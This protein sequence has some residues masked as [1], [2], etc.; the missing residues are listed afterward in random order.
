MRTLGSIIAEYRKKNGI[1][2]TELADSLNSNGY[3]LTNKAISKW[4][5]DVAAP[6]IPVFITLCR[7]LGIEDIYEVFTGY[8]PFNALSSLNTEGREKALEYI[9]LLSE[10]ERY[11]KRSCEII[12]F[13]R[14][15]PLYDLPASAGMG[16]FLD[17]ENYNMIE[18]G[19]EVPAEADFGIRISG[20]SM[21]PRFVHGQIV[22][23]HQ[24]DF[25]QNG[26]IGIFYLD[27]QAFCKKL[28]DDDNGLYLLSLNEEYAPIP[29]K[30]CNTLKIFGKVVG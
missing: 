24:Q 14:S 19:Q 8:N 18:I 21:E 27:G 5:K 2:Q 7:V 12:P 23:V 15:I 29:V 1:S 16:E 4:E 30:N 28:Q 9:Q 26:E 3:S 6:S 25:L 11:Q 10:S 22:W 17:G 13:E 20:N